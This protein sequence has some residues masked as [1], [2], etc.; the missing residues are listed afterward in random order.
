[1]SA[2]PSSMVLLILDGWGYSEEPENNAILAA[3]TPNFDRLWSNSPHT[4]I[5]GSGIDVGLP[6]GQMGNS[7]VGHLNLGAG[8]VVY[9]D[10]TRISKSIQ[11]GDFFENPAL[12][13][14]IDKAIKND[15]AVHLMG[16]LSP[17]GVHSHQD[18]L[19]ALMEMAKKRGAKQLYIHAFLDGRDMPPRSAKESIEA[20]EKKIEELGLGKIVSMTGRYFA[21]DRDQRWDRIEKAYDMMT[22]GI[23]DF[24]ATSALDALE[25]AYSRDEND[26]FVRTTLIGDPITIGDGDALLFI[27]YRADRARQISR[28]FVD[29]E[30]AGFKRKKNP[31]LAD[32][33]MLTQYAADIDAPV[34][35]PP[36]RHK[37]VLGEYIE[38]LGYKQLRIAETEKYAHV[39]F[40]FNG[41]VEKPFDGEERKLIPSPKVATYD[42]Q[43]E[44][45]AEKMTD[46]LVEAIESKQFKVIIGNY[47]NPD[48]VGHTG[49]FEATR[50]AIETIDVCLGRIVSA[51]DKASAEVLI[52]ADHGNAEKMLDHSTGQ[53]HTAHTSG[54]VPFIY[55][56]R[57]ADVVVEDGVLADVAPTLLSLLGLEIPKEMTGR[58]IMKLTEQ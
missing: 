46:E 31:K 34:A 28:A 6:Q 29:K 20:V 32:F 57:D 9:Q 36:L 56:G 44:M 49:N 2:T 55:Y 35:F 7:E 18:H 41:G 42:L 17:G 15:G 40:F 43:P 45:N 47:A 24:Q 38:S 3:N 14:A 8:R 5:S 52:T 1:M 23:A 12:T 4:L 27:N 13:A 26:E 50:K 51:L 21:M 39:T 48:M 19:F 54:P 22:S 11:D 30:F 58:P 37:N 16:L 53:A 10:Y 33:V 25:A